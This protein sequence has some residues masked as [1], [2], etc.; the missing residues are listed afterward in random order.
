MTVTTPGTDTRF[1]IGHTDTGQ[2][3]DWIARSGGRAYNGL[4]TGDDR[5]AVLQAIAD[6]LGAVGVTITTDL[7][8]AEH[9]VTARALTGATP[10][11][12]ALIWHDFHATARAETRDADRVERIARCGPA[13][14]VSVVVGTRTLLPQDFGNN[15]VLRALLH[16]DN[17]VVLH[18]P[19]PFEHAIAG[20][21]LQ[22]F[23]L[24]RDG[25]HAYTVQDGQQIPFRIAA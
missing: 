3:I 24:P 9:L 5:A 1:A 25:G 13:V 10:G 14:G 18:D 16:A 21:L 8:T 20:A 6:N 22:P 4:V 12:F 19:L 7:D 15:T 17:L 11:N 23:A 2:A